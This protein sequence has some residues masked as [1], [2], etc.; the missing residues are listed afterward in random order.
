M[1]YVRVIC[2]SVLNLCKYP[3]LPEPSP[4]TNHSKS[5]YHKREVANNGVFDSG[6]MEGT[7]RVNFNCRLSSKNNILYHLA[8]VVTVIST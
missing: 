3:F 8:L 2:A 6:Y 5:K 1:I 4:N 7:R